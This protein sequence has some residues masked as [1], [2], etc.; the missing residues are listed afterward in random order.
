MQFSGYYVDRTGGVRAGV[1]LDVHAGS[2]IVLTVAPPGALIIDVSAEAE[3][4]ILEH[5]SAE[6]DDCQSLAS[7]EQESRIANVEPPA[8]L[9]CARSVGLARRSNVQAVACEKR[10][11]RDA[12]DRDVGTAVEDEP[13]RRR[14]A[15]ASS[16]RHALY[17]ADQLDV[18]DWTLRQ[19]SNRKPARPRVVRA[20]L[21]KIALGGNRCTV[22]LIVSPEQLRNI[23]L[24]MPLFGR[25]KRFRK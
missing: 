10:R 1:G 2:G 7:I 17:V 19:S 18:A 25:M 12:I 24:V 22:A 6:L 23:T 8:S 5:A 13:V 4:A 9:S 11:G 16:T 21:E 20:S 14:F 15:K 3:I